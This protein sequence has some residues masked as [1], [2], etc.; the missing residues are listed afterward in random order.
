MK[1]FALVTGASEGI[2]KE[3]ARCAARDGYDVILAARSR[4]KLHDLAAELRDRHA[5]EAL[6]IVSDLSRDG[7]AEAL[8]RE[9][10]QGRSVEVVVNN[11][12]LGRHGPF[13]DGGRE[14][15]EASIRV[16]LVA[17]TDLM[18]RA[19]SEMAAR[20]RG[21]ILNVG[22]TAGF[23]PGP[24]MAVYHAT[25]AYV[26]SLSEAV[27]EELRGS[28]VTVTV[29]CPGATQSDF[30]NRADMSEVRLAKM[31]RLPTA[32]S[33]A[34]EGWRAMRA[35]RRVTIT[36][37]TNRAFA[38]AARLLPRRAV[39]AIADRVLAKP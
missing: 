3:L 19:A 16:N 1:G 24:N 36:G 7:A 32:R 37:A 30:F 38:L 20:G 15:E 31:G 21:R 12:G 17:L 34:E 2:G 18:K 26:L 39:T 9:A 23:M 4:E 27:A 13:A 6:A 28:G 11:A 14:R 10:T 33:V 29:L 35:G 25:K 5:V 8:W 22:S